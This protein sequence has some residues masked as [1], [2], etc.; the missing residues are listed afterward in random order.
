M[1][2]QFEHCTMLINESILKQSESQ[3]AEF[4]S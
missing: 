3:E 4:Q 1:N 2:R